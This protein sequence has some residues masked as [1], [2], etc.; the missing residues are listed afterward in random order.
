MSDGR[1]IFLLQKEDVM[2][3]SWVRNMMRNKLLLKI[4]IFCTKGMYA[5]KAPSSLPPLPKDLRH[6]ALY[7]SLYHS[8]VAS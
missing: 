8:I 4:K 1:R 2:R 3:R 7:V 5:V 6:E